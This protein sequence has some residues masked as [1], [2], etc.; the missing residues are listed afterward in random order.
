MDL[1][2]AFEEDYHEVMHVIDETLKAIFKGLQK[3][4]AR[5]VGS[6]VCWGDRRRSAQYI[7]TD[8]YRQIRLSPR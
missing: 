6:T 5:E 8:R 3:Q 7:L 1:E 2:M 4:Y